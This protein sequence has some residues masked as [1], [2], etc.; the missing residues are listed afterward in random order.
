MKGLYCLCVL[1]LVSGCVEKPTAPLVYGAITWPGYDPAYIARELGYLNQSQVHLADF[2]NTT[3]VLH[4]L[5]NGKL[6]VAG[7]TMDE[8]LGVREAIPDLQIFLVADISNGADEL[9]V[10]PEI[11]HLSQLK[12]KRIG[13]EKTALGAYMLTL[14]L[15]AAHLSP[16]DVKIVSLPLDEHVQAYREG[17]LDA[18]VC[19]GLSRDTLSQLGAVPLIDSK[20]LPGKV[21]DTL[22]VRA[23]D[24]EKFSKQLHSFTVSWFRALHEM[25]RDPVRTRPLMEKHERVSVAEIEST[26]AGL[27]LVGRE[28][29]LRLL[30]GNPPALLA[31]AREVQAI[32]K[33]SGLPIGND[34]FSQ[35]INSRI[36]TEAGVD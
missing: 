23:A 19:S 24:A 15:R 12:G 35:L 26:M 1:I 33:D 7:L 4:A 34:D 29:N 8:A 16:N 36:V 3:E 18:V 6:Q 21:V 20:T 11:S 27:L 2:T 5:R 25:Q 30:A 17:L 13:V 14:I 28:E 32:M 9:M 22:V 10:K 31:T